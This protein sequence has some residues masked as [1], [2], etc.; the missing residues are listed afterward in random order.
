M[1]V[2]LTSR[3]ISEKYNRFARWYDWLEGILNLLGLSRLRRVLL[4]RASGK[5]LEVAVGT[6]K[7]L[8]YYPRDCRIIALDL[9][10]E[11]LKVARER[12][13][14]LSLNVSFLV[15][16]A[17]APPFSDHCFD[18]V[19]SSLSICTFP[20]PAGAIREM[21]RVCKPPGRILLLEHG[22][23][24]REWLG[25][26]QDRHAEQFAKPL[27]CH[28]NREPLELARKAGLNVVEVQRIFFGIFHHIEAEPGRVSPASGRDEH[29][30]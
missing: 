14:R 3:E 4:R 17:E 1:A 26:W 9:S 27:G 24:D 19:V 7:N 25:R 21:A 6:G 12:A 13:A 18:T 30:V 5:V 2:D 10:R 28:W 29:D 23:S 20:N 11:M 8:I 22:R 16:D 15:A